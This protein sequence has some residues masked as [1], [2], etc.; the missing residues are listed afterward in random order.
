MNSFSLPSFSHPSCLAVSIALIMHKSYPLNRKNI[1]V[2]IYIYICVCVCL[3]VRV[4][5]CVFVYLFVYLLVYL[6]NC[7]YVSR[8]YPAV[9]S[10]EI[11]ALNTH[12]ELPPALLCATQRMLSVF[13]P[14]ADCTLR[15]S[16]PRGAPGVVWPRWCSGACT[17]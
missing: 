17:G 3:I 4:C 13:R 2:C 12:F 14:L 10:A 8:I 9:L 16:L 15:C 11:R 7:S 1:Y 5:V 6:L